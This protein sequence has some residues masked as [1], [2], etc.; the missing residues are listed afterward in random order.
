MSVRALVAEIFN[1]LG[2]AIPSSAEITTAFLRWVLDLLA[3]AVVDMAR[4][5][6]QLVVRS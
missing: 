1:F 3:R 5:A 4:Q 6:M 2:R